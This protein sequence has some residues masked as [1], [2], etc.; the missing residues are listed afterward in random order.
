MG[1]VDGPW[2]R[3]PEN[4]LK[5]HLTVYGVY[6]CVSIRPVAVDA[7][8]HL[9]A[10]IDAQGTPA[11]YVNGEPSELRFRPIALAREAVA[12]DGAPLA[13]TSAIPTPVG[14]MTG[15]AA[16]IGRNP[17]GAD[18]LITPERWQGHISHVA[19]YDRAL[20]ADEISQ[21]YQATRK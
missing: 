14:Q 10:S 3:F 2:Y 4:E 19:L 20:N 18:G 16:R 9:A 17:A 12:P 1:L 15:G 11:L 8:V 6:D 21:H 5:F 13:W 7:W